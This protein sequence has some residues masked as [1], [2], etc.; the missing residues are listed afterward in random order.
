M[1]NLERANTPSLAYREPLL[2]SASKYYYSILGDV[3]GQ[4]P[5]GGAC[6]GPSSFLGNN[7]RH[8]KLI[9]LFLSAFETASKEITPQGHDL[10]LIDLLTEFS[11][12]NSFCRNRNPEVQKVRINSMLEILGF[13]KEDQDSINKMISIA[14]EI[15]SKDIRKTKAPYII[16]PLGI[17]ATMLRTF[18]MLSD[19]DTDPHG[20]KITDETR[21]V[22]KDLVIFGLF[23]DTIEDQPAKV[24]DWVRKHDGIHDKTLL[25]KA[26]R[27]TQ[28]IKLTIEKIFEENREEKVR[29]EKLEKFYTQV[30][31][32]VLLRHFLDI[33][34]N[35]TVELLALTKSP[36][37]TKYFY[38]KIAADFGIYAKLVKLFDRLN[39]HEEYEGFKPIKIPINILTSMAY[40]FGQ[41][42]NEPNAEDNPLRALTKQ[43]KRF[44]EPRF[45]QIYLIN[46]T[47]FH[48]K[49]FDNRTD[50]S[51]EEIAFKQDPMGPEKMLAWLK[52]EASKV[53]E[54]DLLL[55]PEK[56]IE[57]FLFHEYSPQILGTA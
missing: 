18:I 13:S 42:S 20:L 16:H 50:L 3:L 10:S 24:I 19:D 2:Y 45:T 25:P 38:E 1:E 37:D 43:C 35:A 14:E 39:N 11:E 34:E 29:K 30:E 49:Y 53:G 7:S 44:L 21:N 22:I 4:T 15:H 23:H 54:Y 46:L 57:S 28:I 26:A 41:D 12:T 56:L 27:Y 55:P 48:N 47:H 52:S 8:Q 40:I 31:A 32:A 17:V 51:T 9:W 36:I 33:Q 6:H 5:G